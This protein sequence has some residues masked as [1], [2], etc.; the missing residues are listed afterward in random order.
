MD[1]KRNRKLKAVLAVV[2]AGIA[3]VPTAQAQLRTDARHAAL[4]Q[5]ETPVQVDARHQALLHRDARSVTSVSI[6]TSG[7]DG[8][9]W[10]DAGL[11]AAA[12]LGLAAAG[13][14]SLV[15][16]RKKLAQA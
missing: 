2:A 3:A 6:V 9:D 15:L 10:T 5:K 1:G 12:A 4:L 14:A 11:G 16:S 7:A 13:G 8:F